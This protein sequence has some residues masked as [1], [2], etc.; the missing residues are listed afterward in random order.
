MRRQTGHFVLY[1]AQLPGQ[2][3]VRLGLAVSRQIGNAVVR[4]RIKRRLRESFRCGLK[5]IL[6]RTTALMVI[7][8]E[9]AARLKTQEITAELITPLS[10]MVVDKLESTR[11]RQS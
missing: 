9:G 11:T 7:A 1:L 6:P 10:Q 2:E 3:A 5:A 4:N 8:R